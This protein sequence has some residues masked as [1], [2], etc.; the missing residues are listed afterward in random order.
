MLSN[1]AF[2]GLG[3]GGRIEVGKIK[4]K[5]E[6]LYQNEGVVYSVVVD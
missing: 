1:I 5:D 3:G 6:L 4:K 2:R